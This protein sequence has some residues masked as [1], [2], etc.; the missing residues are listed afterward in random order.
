MYQY[1]LELIDM[2]T[3]CSLLFLKVKTTAGDTKTDTINSQPVQGGAKVNEI[4]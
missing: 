2:S 4:I 1:V 3:K